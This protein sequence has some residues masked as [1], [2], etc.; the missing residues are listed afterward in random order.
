MDLAPEMVQRAIQK[1]NDK[2]VNIVVGSAESLPFEDQIFDRYFS[3]YCLHL[4][5]NP[6]MCSLSHQF[7][8]VGWIH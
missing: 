6:G 8:D 2:D 3:S 7:M 5:P 4:V 1:V